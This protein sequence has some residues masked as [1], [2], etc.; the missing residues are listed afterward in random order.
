MLKLDSRLQKASRSN[1]GYRALERVRGSTL[2]GVL[3]K[4]FIRWAI[5]E[6][7]HEPEH[8]Q[9]AASPRRP[10]AG[11]E[12]PQNSDCDSEDDIDLSSVLQ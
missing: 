10:A 7:I 11:D 4:K 3:P 12:Q 6:D 8:M 1:N 5:R 9:Q 2:D